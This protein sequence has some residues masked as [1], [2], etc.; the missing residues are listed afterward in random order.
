ML[1]TR[2]LSQDDPTMTLEMVLNRFQEMGGARVAGMG[3]MIPP[4]FLWYHQFGYKERWN[5]A[6]WSD[7]SMKR[8]FDEYYQEAMDKGW[9]GQPHGQDLAG[10]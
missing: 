9:W 7:K 4:A 3:G 8:T 5:K 6:E 10:C 2:R 1:A